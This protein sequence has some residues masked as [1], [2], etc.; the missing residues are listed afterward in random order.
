VVVAARGRCH[1]QKHPPS[2]ERG[3]DLLQ[4][5][6]RRANRARDHVAEHRQR[7]HEDAHAAQDHQRR[8]QPVEHLPLEVAVALQYQCAEIGHLRRFASVLR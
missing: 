1:A 5:Q 4:P 2:E 3:G 7:E 6:P 8:F